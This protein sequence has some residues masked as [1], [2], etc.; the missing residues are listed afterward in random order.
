MYILV[1][2]GSSCHRRGS[3]DVMN[4]VRELITENVLGNTV[5]INSSFC[6]GRCHLEGITIKIDDQFIYGVGMENIDDI[7]NTYVLGK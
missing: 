1:C 3:Y 7:F 6:L 2:I 4:R 5:K